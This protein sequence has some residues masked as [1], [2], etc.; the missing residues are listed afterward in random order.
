MFDFSPVCMVPQY[1]LN[2][3]PVKIPY[4][5]VCRPLPKIAATG[6]IIAQKCSSLPLTSKIVNFVKLSSELT[7]VIDKHVHRPLRKKPKSVSTSSSMPHNVGV[8]NAS[9]SQPRVHHTHTLPAASLLGLVL[10]RRHASQTSPCVLTF[11]TAQNSRRY[12]KIPPLLY[13]DAERLDDAIPNAHICNRRLAAPSTNFLLDEYAGLVRRVA[14]SPPHLSE[15]RR[16]GLYAYDS[17]TIRLLD[18]CSALFGACT[19]TESVVPQIAATWWY[20]E[21]EVHR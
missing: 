13:M 14:P 10:L 8:S 12:R 21:A 2:I 3:N 5:E 1:C 16:I 17:D 9:C 6:L 15:A 18:A 20:Y 19:E 11:A 4:A 7:R